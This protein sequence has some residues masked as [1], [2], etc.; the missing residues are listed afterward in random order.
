M[1]DVIQR[2]IAAEA[3]AK[4]IVEIAV[5]E[6]ERISSEARKQGEHLVAQARLEANLEAERMLEVS[7][8]EAE[9]EKQKRLAGV[10]AEIE[11]QVCLDSST[12][13]RAIAGAIRC[14]CGRS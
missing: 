5:A 1:R 10:S 12:R 3:E 7:L 2:I 6:A 13:E 8:G 4:R 11:A 14:V 9:R